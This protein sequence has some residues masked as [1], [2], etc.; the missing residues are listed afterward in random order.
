MN[1]SNSLVVLKPPPTP[2]RKLPQTDAAIP[3][4][5]RH[6]PLV[7]AASAMHAS[8]PDQIAPLPRNMSLV[9]PNQSMSRRL[10][11]WL[12]GLVDH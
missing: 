3:L 4:S 2:M 10:R 9:D 6:E 12:V 8:L 11:N 1:S 7:M 5:Q